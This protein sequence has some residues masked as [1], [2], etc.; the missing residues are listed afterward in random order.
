MKSGVYKCVIYYDRKL[1][2][3]VEQF[4]KLTVAEIESKA[5]GSYMDG[6]R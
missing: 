1:C 3:T 2:D 5:Y 6:A 4:E